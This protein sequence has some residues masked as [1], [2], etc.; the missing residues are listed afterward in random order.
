MRPLPPVAYHDPAETRPEIQR[1]Y[2]T[3]VYDGIFAQTMA[4]LIT[5]S[6]FTAFLLALGASNT[7]IGLL[8]AA[9]PLT[10][11]LQWPAV[12][13]VSRAGSWRQVTVLTAGIGRSA[14][15]VVV[16]LPW[17]APESWRLPL[18]LLAI[19][20]HFVSNAVTCCAF[21]A[22]MRALIPGESAGRFFG[23]RTAWST[24]VSVV[25]GLLAGYVVHRAELAGNALLGYSISIMA[26]T[27]VGWAGL[28]FLAKTPDA[29]RAALPPEA[30]AAP[31]IT[32]AQRNVYVFLALWA[33]ALALVQ[34]FMMVYL[35]EH[36]HVGTNWAMALSMAGQ[37]L[38]VALFPAWGR[39]A[40][41]FTNRAVLR[42]TCTGGA[43][44]FLL[45]PVAAKMPGLPL[46][47]FVATVALLLGG[48]LQSGALLC[49]YLINLKTAPAASP[50]LALAR[51]NFFSGLAAILA[52][53]LAGRLA[54]QADTWAWLSAL[55]GLGLDVVFILAAVVGLGSALWL[56]QVEESGDGR[57]RDVLRA[58]FGGAV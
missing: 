57:G 54:D 50:V 42:L 17:L 22:W 2:R 38:N 12:R 46:Q 40:D 29:P 6:F 49:C 48:A 43:L 15:V 26:G 35:L 36:L 28:W 33:F 16:F 37:A 14:W 20:V 5:G 11:A 9:G 55:G 23:H 3:L 44:A 27:L 45:W 21:N 53:A 51:G 47:V 7:L 24:A 10:Q 8:S 39:L 19:S 13:W 58:L 52:S 32:P 31:P 4:T 41:R 56:Q 1:A 25:A 30:A 34:P 18:I